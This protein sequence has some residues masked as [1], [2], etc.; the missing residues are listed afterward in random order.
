MLEYLQANTGGVGAFT[1]LNHQAQSG[2]QFIP[3]FHLRGKAMY[4]KAEKLFS[5]L[6]DMATSANF[7]DQK[8][9]KELILKHY[10]NLHSSIVPNALKYAMNLSSSGLNIAGK[11]NNAWYGLDYLYNIKKLATQ[12]DAEVEWLVENLERMKETLLCSR[13]PHLVLS[14]EQSELGRFIENGFEG[15]QELPEHA[16]TPWKGAYELPNLTNQGRILA[17]QVAFTC[18]SCKTISYS[19]PDSAALSLSTFLFDNLTLHKRVREQGGAYGSGSLANIMSGTF[20]FYSYRDPNIASTIHAFD[21]ALKV[22]Q[23]HDFDDRDL[24]EAKLEMIQGLDSPIAPGTRADVAY[25]WWREGKTFE[26]R[27]AFRDAVMNATC[28]DV[29]RTVEQHLIPAFKDAVAVSFA[30]KELLEKEN[31]ELRKASLAP[32]H[33]EKVWV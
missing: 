6:F 12:F 17:S 25:G 21:E 2:N 10:T 15:L 20:A 13:G 23:N 19:H 22:V 24:E 29:V 7:T 16:I 31:N 3:S 1:S 4:H 9:L 14:C 5:L 28:L 26:M 30:G 8:R 27:Q 33:I 18:K 11:I 32:L